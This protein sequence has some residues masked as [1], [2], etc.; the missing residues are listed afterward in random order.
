M[1]TTKRG[2]T[3]KVKKGHMGTFNENGDIC[4]AQFIQNCIKGNVEG[5]KKYKVGM[6]P[7]SSGLATIVPP[8]SQ[9]SI[10][11]QH[12]LRLYATLDQDK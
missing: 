6:G 3:T 10:D 7:V 11:L 9:I 1:D 5:L 8:M 2:T 12:P 4:I